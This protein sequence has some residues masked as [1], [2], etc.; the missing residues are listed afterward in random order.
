MGYDL[1]SINKELFY[2]FLLICK[3]AKLRLY[4]IYK[5][6]DVI[7]FYI[8]IYQRYLIHKLN[9][10]IQYIKSKGILSYFMLFLYKKYSTIFLLSFF[11]SFVLNTMLI[12]DVRI[13]GTNQKLNQS[14]MNNI[15]Q[16][17]ID[18][19]KK[20]ISYEKLNDILI[21]MKLAYKDDIEYLSLYQKGGIFYVEYIPF[22]KEF[23]NEESFS[24]IYAASDGLINYIDVDSGVVKVKINDY[25][26]KGDLLVENYVMSTQNILSIM[27]VKAKI[28]AYTFHQY[29]ATKNSKHND[30]VELFYE[31]LL[32][33][34][35]KINTGA[36][37]DVE[38]VL[39]MD[40][41]HSTIT[42]KM[43]YTLIEDI[44]VE[45]EL[46]EENH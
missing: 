23:V 20:K 27:P 46:N 43:H 5:K 7:Y 38:K 6:D 4:Q 19:F 11:V 21:D 34:R 39:Q 8:P 3:N 17:D 41:S 42:L 35:S 29:T 1:Y 30:Y 13:V 12:M 10:P 16:Y 45:G 15:K 2:D 22:K 24:N 18:L 44:A 26:K 25:V 36:Q 31:L 9:L 28:Y 32:S 14:I 37:I 40:R 33:I